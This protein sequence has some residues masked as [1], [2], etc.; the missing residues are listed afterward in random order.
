MATS[1]MSI[2]LTDKHS[3]KSKKKVRFNLD[4]NSTNTN[5]PTPDDTHHKKLTALQI[6]H[7]RNVLG[8]K[9]MFLFNYGKPLEINSDI[10][11]STMKLK[12]NNQYSDVKN[13]PLTIN[14][15]T[16]TT[17]TNNTTNTNE[18]PKKKQKTSHQNTNKQKPKNKQLTDEITSKNITTDTT[19]TMI[20]S[21]IDNLPQNSHEHNSTNTT[22]VT[23]NQSSN[24]IAKPFKK[25]KPKPQWHRP[26]K[27]Y[28]VISGHL[29]WVQSVCMDPSNE[30]FITGSADRTIKIWDLASGS[31]KL[32]LTGHISS[33]RGVALSSA[34]PYMFSCGEDKKVCCWDLTQK[35]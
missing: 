7:R 1:T 12:I 8:T 32:T 18:P 25:K 5:T 23:Y 35:K 21:I 17:N 15:P 4:N 24:Q 30:Y 11:E 26:W 29:G 28:R 20:E 31:L 2:L 14:N 34:S 16:I 13:H 33:V 19:S 6:A 10:I 3:S 9:D 22:I 27:P